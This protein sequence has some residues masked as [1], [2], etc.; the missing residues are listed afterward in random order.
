MRKLKSTVIVF[1][2]GIFFATVNAQEF[3]EL[4]DIWGYLEVNGTMKQYSD[5]YD[6]LLN[7]MERQFPKSDRNGNGWLYLERNK[8]KAL[9]EMKDLLAPIYLQHFTLDEI[10]QMRQFYESDP[11]KQ[12]V[13]DR[14][15]LTESQITEVDAFF[16]STL[17]EKLKQKQAVLTTEI[18]AASEY[19]SK[20][21]YQTAALLLKE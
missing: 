9:N 19:W 13:T 20:D 3:S 5:A 14:G 4:K 1:I 15:G 10:K 6:E 17:G 12:L 8:T 21:L 11:G 7:L 16:N 18:E 2:L